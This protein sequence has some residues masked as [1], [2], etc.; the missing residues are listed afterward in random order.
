[1]NYER[2]GE[3]VPTKRRRKSSTDIYHVT[4]KGINKE[5]IFNQIRERYYFKKI[6]LKHLGKYDVKIYAYCIM[7]NHIHIIIRSELNILSLFMAKVLAE[8]AAYYNYKHGRNGHVF[9]NRFGSE[10]IETTQYLWNC[11]RYIH[12]NPVKAKMAKDVCTY[13]FSSMKEF[14]QKKAVVIHENVITMWEKR[15][16]NFDNFLDFHKMQD[17]CTYQDVA[18]DVD[19]QMKSA[20]FVILSAMAEV[21]KVKE[22]VE[23]LEDKILREKYLQSLKSSLNISQKKA[24]KLYNY[25]KKSIMTK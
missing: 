20:A 14:Q 16:D 22:D 10:C 9:Q 13:K 5:Q 25:I 3:C 12:M 18:A 11:V 15:F 19:M 6:L 24:D 7:S 1:M 21:E 2:M 8:Y 17:T 4:A 23:I